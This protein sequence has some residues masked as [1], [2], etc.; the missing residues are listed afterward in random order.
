VLHALGVRARLDHEKV[1]VVVVPQRPGRL[2]ARAVEALGASGRG[3]DHGHEGRGAQHHRG[4]RRKAGGRAG[5]NSLVGMYVC[6]QVYAGSAYTGMS[7]WEVMALGC[8]RLYRVILMRQFGFVGR[9]SRNQV[10]SIR[11][12]TAVCCQ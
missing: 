5:W 2:V 1:R 4:D 7:V 10:R 12:R 11:S 8:L 9:G 6:M 3:K